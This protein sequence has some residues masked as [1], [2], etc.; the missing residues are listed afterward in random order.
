MCVCVRAR[1]EAVVSPTLQCLQTGNVCPGK[2]EG[3]L[4]PRMANTGSV[5]GHTHTHADI[6]KHTCNSL[7]KKEESDGSASLCE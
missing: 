4:P 6:Q 1:Q 7:K 3:T 2:R 5:A